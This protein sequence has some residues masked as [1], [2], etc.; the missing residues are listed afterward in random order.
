M[1][2]LPLVTDSR[3]PKSFNVDYSEY[4]II[5]K[6]RYTNGVLDSDTFGT[7]T[8][9]K[10]VYDDYYGCVIS[11][12]HRRRNSGELLPFTRY[13][14]C[15]ITTEVSGP[16]ELVY[17]FTSSGGNIRVYKDS[18]YDNSNLPLQTN[19][20]VYGGYGTDYFVNILRDNLGV[21]PKVFVQRAAARLYGRGWDGMTFLAEFSQ[22]VRMF[23]GCIFQFIE[24]VEA[25]LKDMSKRNTGDAVLKTFNQWLQG[26]YGWRVLVYDIKDINE[27]ILGI[28][29]EQRTRS[30][31]RTGQSY[32]YTHDRS[33][34]NTSDHGRIITDI[35]ELSF[36]VRG[37]VI[38][39]FMPNK[40]TLNPVVTAWEL[41]PYS[42]VVD[43]FYNVGQALNALSFLSVNNL[44]TASYGIHCEVNRSYSVSV[45]FPNPAWGSPHSNADQFTMTQTGTFKLRE[46]CFVSSLP[47]ININL[48]SFKV[49]DLI[50]LIGQSLLKL[51][52]S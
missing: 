47:S 10:Y 34:V 48:N 31:E 22:V 5:R 50:A 32:T 28:D 19:G 51:T 49:M 52:R 29:K 9:R 21:D 33:K 25:Y 45:Y 38:A 20:L 11:D 36:S 44:Y 24:L 43:W 15:K 46:P 13:R 23:R 3:N 17:G 14:N 7:S 1:P 8:Q 12:Y 6:R 40:I 35:S 4:R 26:R 39:D 30:K 41:V 37:S 16:S 2:S 42:F 27:L 18:W